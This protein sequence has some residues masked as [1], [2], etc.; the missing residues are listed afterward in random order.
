MAWIPRAAGRCTPARSRRTSQT[1]TAAVSVAASPTDPSCGWV[2]AG[3]VAGVLVLLVGT[4]NG[5]PAHHG[6]AL[7]MGK[8]FGGSCNSPPSSPQQ[9]SVVVGSTQPL[10]TAVRRGTCHPSGGA[11]LLEIRVGGSRGCEDGRGR[12]RDPGRLAPGLP[13]WTGG[14]GWRRARTGSVPCGVPIGGVAATWLLTS[15]PRPSP[16]LLCRAAPAARHELLWASACR[17]RRPAVAGM[18]E[19]WAVLPTSSARGCRRWPATDLPMCRP[20]R[21]HPWSHN[22]K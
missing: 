17:Q 13:R 22:T 9:L 7:W 6:C 19:A 4:A 1:S 20:W 15:S 16:P 2:A 11:R 5:L 21:G 3:V 10:I 18:A 8:S 14:P 12:C